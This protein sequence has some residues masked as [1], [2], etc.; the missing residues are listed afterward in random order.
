MDNI[1]SKL[2][3]IISNKP[4]SE[5][6]LQKY[7]NVLKISY[8]TD[9]EILSSTSDKSYGLNVLYSGGIKTYMNNTSNPEKGFTTDIGWGCMIRSMQSLVANALRLESSKL[10]TIL[11]NM[12]DGD[13]KEF[14]LSIA[15][16]FRDDPQY[17][18]SIH[19]ITKIGYEF[20]NVN[21]G[22]WFGPS[23]GAQCMQK[24]ICSQKQLIVDKCCVSVD[25][26]TLY[27]D[28]LTEYFKLNTSKSVLVLL[29][30][31][32]GLNKINDEYIN[33]FY[34][35]FD[36]GNDYKF[37][38]IAGG[39]PYK[40][41]Y[42]FDKKENFLVYAD[43][44]HVSNYSELSDDVNLLLD[45]KNNYKLDTTTIDELDPSM[46]IGYVIK[47]LEGLK[48]MKNRYKNSSIITFKNKQEEQAMLRSLDVDDCY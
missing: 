24:I 35:L 47:S 8:K 36:S 38:G 9:F 45:F 10:E 31:R 43:P 23:V 13:N 17:P 29:C 21:I 7:R 27:E 12:P 6:D 3:S 14:D 18:F 28:E 40:S 5:D 46:C 4:L 30:V 20:F 2:G 11:D 15:R 1:I 19:N 48:D 44:H 39:K 41:L 32:L 34:D 42:F 16:M 26:G 37:V 25:S 33:S 22:D